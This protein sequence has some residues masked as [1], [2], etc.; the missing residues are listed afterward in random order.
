MNLG[1]LR[2][3]LPLVAPILIGLSAFAITVSLGPQQPTGDIEIEA[4]PKDVKVMANGEA[5][6]TGKSTLP[7]GRYKIEVTKKG[8]ESQS[9]DITITESDS[10][11]LGFVLEPNTEDTRGWYDARPRDKSRAEGIAGRNADARSSRSTQNNTLLQ[12]LPY[13]FGD[14]NRGIIRLDTGTAVDNSDET[15]VYITAKTPE[16]RQTALTWIRGQGYNPG[17]MDIV[18]YDAQTKFITD[19]D[20]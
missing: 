3:A 19:K 15:A 17:D 4:A 12:M 18:F 20:Y 11:Y 14:G 1:F 7:P 8:F 16:A 9:E 2:S 5:I 6:G 10:I 13:E